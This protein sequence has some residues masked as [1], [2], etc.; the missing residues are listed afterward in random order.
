MSECIIIFLSGG[1]GNQ[2][3]QY[4]AGLAVMSKL[5]GTLWL[6]PCEMNK[7][8]GRDYRNRLY[9]RA[10][11]I[12]PDGAPGEVEVQ[13]EQPDPFEAWN[14]ED[15]SNI[16]SVSLKGYYQYLPPIESQIA[17]V[18]EDLFSRLSDIRSLMR[19][20]YRIHNARQ[21]S[22]IHVRRGDY[23]IS[24]PSIFFVQGES[25]F[26]PAIQAINQH[27]LGNRR[28]L[29]V[30]D[31]IAWC[32]QQPWLE[33]YDFIDEPDELN[34]LMVMSLCQAGA[35]I[36]NSTFGWWG[37]VLGCGEVGSPV[38]YPGKWIGNNTPD[39]FLPNWTR[40]E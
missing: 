1:I 4:S 39:L 34:G 23:L 14:P 35:V 24:D 5:G 16:R 3:F 32:R 6:T 10:K 40:I 28:W 26:I 11:A 22:F 33:K 15:Y 20:K 18:R 29:V 2:L 8:S 30:S 21:T 7:H 38:A 25:Y 36:S 9:I 12:G 17:L 27:S 31:D 37:A 19:E 13:K